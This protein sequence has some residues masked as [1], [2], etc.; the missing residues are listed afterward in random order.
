M[1][2]ALGAADYLTKPIDVGL[3]TRV[4]NRHQGGDG[5]EARVLV[6]D[7]DPGTREVLRRALAREGW[8]V[9]VAVDGYKGLAFLRRSRPAVV[10]LDLMMPGMDGF[11]VLHAMRRNETWRDIPVVVITARDLTRE[12]AD[13]LTR[14]AEAVFQKGAYERGELIDEVERMV[15][16]RVPA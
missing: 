8:T 16:R 6:I 7:D 13:W 14:H 3:L 2:Y 1:G 9:A 12:E 10:L 11:E 4:L 5:R 15:A